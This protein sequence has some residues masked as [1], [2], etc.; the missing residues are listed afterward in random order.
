M[1]KCLRVVAFLAA[2]LALGALPAIAQI[3]IP[4]S[5]RNPYTV[6]GRG[7]AWGTAGP[8]GV[9]NNF[10]FNPVSADTTVCVY[11]TNNNPTNLHSVSLAVQQTGDPSVSSFTTSQNPWASVQTP[12]VF[13]ISVAAHTTQG[14]FFRSSAAA[15]LVLQVSGST[16]A[17]GSPDTADV[18]AVMPSIAS[19]CGI[20]TLSSIQSVQGVYAEGATV[21]QA[22][23][24]PVLIGGLGIS[25]GVVQ[26]TI[27]TPRIDQT[28]G[29]MY[30][31]G[32]TT[33]SDGANAVT[34][35]ALNSN[36]VN[37]NTILSTLQ[38]GDYA[39]TTCGICVTQFKNSRR[40]GLVTS[41]AWTYRATLLGANGPRSSFW[42][43]NDSVNPAASQL[44]V[45][46]VMGGSA[47]S[48]TP[49]RAIVS[50]SAACDVT[51]NKIS[52]AGT[53]C[54]TPTAFRAMDNASGN[55]PQATVIRGTCAAN[56]TVL[57]VIHHI[58]VA[59]GTTQTVDLAGYWQSAT[60]SG[61]DI[62]AGA[63]LTGTA[64]VTL[65]YSEAVN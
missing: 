41:S 62:A 55:A 13:P 14:F 26:N 9:N 4:I 3:D 12:Q 33:V 65:E 44:L 25:G 10:V 60:T 63:A 16:T 46:V 47:P 32:Q 28:T 2:L 40:Y 54:G 34:Q 36:N 6:I 52:N 49:N 50:C 8:G 35:M 58:W 22:S 45:G 37:Q 23:R 17:G 15:R 5:G 7:L 38:Y 20:S 1:R 27:L 24:F 64:S 43:Q 11:V 39:D 57:A 31:G 21:A 51:I 42:L 18:F 56:P 19:S 59:A 61:F 48:I 30:V 29:G 53:T